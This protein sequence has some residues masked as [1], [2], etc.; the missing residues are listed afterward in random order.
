MQVRLAIYANAYFTCLEEALE[1]DYEILK[2]L[3]GEDVFNEACMAYTIN[4]R[5]TTIRY[6][7]SASTFLNFWA[8]K[9]IAVNTTG[10]RRKCRIR[11]RCPC[12]PRAF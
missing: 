10:M 3:L 1:R 9:L 6:A 4:I 5:L 2:K 8:I 11:N 12:V 7:G